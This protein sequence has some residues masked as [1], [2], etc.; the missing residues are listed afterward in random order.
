MW[1]GQSLA[2]QAGQC[3]SQD[4]SVSQA[5]PYPR[6]GSVPS[7]G[8]LATSRLHFPTWVLISEPK[9]FPFIIT[10]SHLDDPVPSPNL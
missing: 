2:E 8:T 3:Q 5:C 7:L 1:P 4:Q 6:V 10:I 9:D